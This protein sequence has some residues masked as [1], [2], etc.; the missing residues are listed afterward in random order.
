MIFN[1]R[2]AYLRRTPLTT[3]PKSDFYCAYLWSSVTRLKENHWFFFK[4]TWKSMKAIEDKWKFNRHLWN[5]YENHGKSLKSFGN[6]WN[7][8]GSLW[9]LINI[10]EG[11]IRLQWKP[12][13]KREKLMQIIENNENKR[14]S[15]PRQL[16]FFLAEAL[17]YFSIKIWAYMEVDHSIRWTI[18]SQA[19]NHAMH[20]PT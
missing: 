2:R 18:D 7:S 5:T 6:Q 12:K 20:A 16:S 3:P 13:T 10:N 19:C 1:P 14:F 17:Y 4:G 8:F 9:N 11:E 15:A